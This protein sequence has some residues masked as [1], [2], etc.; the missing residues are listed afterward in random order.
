M[1]TVPGCP[2]CSTTVDSGTVIEESAAP[3]EAP[4]APAPDPAA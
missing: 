1:S 4:A 3:A 2:N